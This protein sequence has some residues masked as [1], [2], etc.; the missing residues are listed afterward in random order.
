MLC[1]AACSAM[2]RRTCSACLHGRAQHGRGPAAVRHA[3]CRSQVQS[4][5]VIAQVITQVSGAVCCGD[6]PGEKHAH[7]PVR[8]NCSSA[9]LEQCAAATLSFG[10]S[11]AATRICRPQCKTT[12]VLRKRDCQ[13]RQRMVQHASLHAWQM[14][15]AADHGPPHVP[16]CM[17]E[18][19][20]HHAPSSARAFS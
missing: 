16:A 11:N 17:A 5:A 13:L 2:S 4:A 14:P 18:P 8:A 9:W 12:R 15:L 3:C 6:R 10:L 20:A 1:S 7:G 19:R